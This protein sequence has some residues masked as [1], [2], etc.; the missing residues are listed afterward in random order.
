MSYFISKTIEGQ[1]DEVI[2]R[3]TNELKFIGFGVLTVIDVKKTLKMKINDDFKPYTILG[4]CNPHFASKALRLEDKLGVV[5]PCN[6]VVIEQ[7]PNRIEVAAIDPIAMMAG[8]GNEK[9]DKLA[10]EVSC[11]L[12]KMITDL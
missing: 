11:K 12:E 4:A 10:K 8:I 7:A 9:L 6:V 1:F 3:V 2:E 5:L